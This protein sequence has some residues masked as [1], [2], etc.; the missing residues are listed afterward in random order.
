L[1]YI[2]DNPANVR[3]ITR[4]LARRPAIEMLCA[5]TGALAL[6][7][8]RNCRPDLILLD[9]HLPDSHGDEVLTQLR[10]D[11]STA[12]IPVVILT[13]DVQPGKR[14]QLVA[15]G[16]RAFLAKRVVVRSFLATIDQFIEP[17]A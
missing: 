15:A 6:K 9:L 17:G 14:E 4:I 3:L 7:M 1:L 10:A 13:A 11:P 5:E 12:Q 2:E 8:A 16:A